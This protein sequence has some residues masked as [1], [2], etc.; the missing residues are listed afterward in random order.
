MNTNSEIIVFE[1]EGRDVELSVEYS[2]E[3]AEPEN[4]VEEQFEI[5][6]VDAIYLEHDSPQWGDAAW[7]GIMFKDLIVEKIKALDDA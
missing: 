1:I 2:H 5:T 4:D 6:A 7:L 3:S